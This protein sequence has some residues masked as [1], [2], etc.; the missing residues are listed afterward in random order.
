MQHEMN[1]CG[2]PF[3]MI[4]SGEKTIEL[5]LLDEKRQRI[6]VGDTLLFKNADCPEQALSCRVLTLHHFDS[7]EELYAHLP[8]LK[9]GYT[10][11][12][13]ASARPEDMDAYYPKEKQAQY[14]VGRI[15]LVLAD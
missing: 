7:F 4:Q 10:A 8:L 3:S 1:L 9:C 14:G 2:Q 11:S 12:D 5:R 13:I 15:E 6:R